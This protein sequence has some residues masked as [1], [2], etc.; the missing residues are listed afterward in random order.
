[1]NLPTLTH[2]Q[3]RA[4][5][6]RAESLSALPFAPPAIRAAGAQCRTLS[7]AIFGARQGERERISDEIR[8]LSGKVFAW[9]REASDEASILSENFDREEIL[10]CNGLR[11]GRHSAILDDARRSDRWRVYR[12][13]FVGG[14]ET[15][16]YLVTVDAP[17]GSAAI[18]QATRDPG[19]A[20]SA[21]PSVDR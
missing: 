7:A 5:A 2:S 17:S 20:A 19:D 18:A 4:L 10:F 1:M 6:L 3:A 13:T 11:I 8:S 14:E 9:I 16:A 21:L 12:H 15:E